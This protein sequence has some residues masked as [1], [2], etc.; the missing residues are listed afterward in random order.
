MAALSVST[1]DGSCVLTADDDATF[2]TVGDLTLAIQD[3]RGVRR[4][5]LRLVL[6]E[7]ILEDDVLL[8]ALGAT[9]LRINLVTLSYQEDDESRQALEEAIDEIVNFVNG[10]RS[11]PDETRPVTT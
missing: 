7:R 9:P 5:Q 4:F 2:E 6:G 1:M 11:K 10:E 8:E 3:R